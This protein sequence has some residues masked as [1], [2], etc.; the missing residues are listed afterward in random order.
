MIASVGHVRS[1]NIYTYIYIYR[2]RERVSNVGRFRLVSTTLNVGHLSA[3]S[4]IISVVRLARL[5]I[6]VTVGHLRV[7][8]L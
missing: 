5:S 4:A 1:H 8:M 6:T 2:E 3:P 7:S